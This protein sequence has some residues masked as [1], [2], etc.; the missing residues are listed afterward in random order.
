MKKK[1]EKLS[2]SSNQILSP[3]LLQLLIHSSRLQGTIDFKRRISFSFV[4]CFLF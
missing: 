1:K 2:I 4:F 3:F